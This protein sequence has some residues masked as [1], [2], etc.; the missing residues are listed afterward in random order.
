MERDSFTSDPT[1]L[2]NVGRRS[3]KRLAHVVKRRR[4]SA[5]GDASEA[6]VRASIE[7]IAAASKRRSNSRFQKTSKKYKFPTATREQEQPT[8]LLTVQAT[9]ASEREVVR[10][11]VTPRR[12]S[13]VCTARPATAKANSKSQVSWPF[14]RSHGRLD[15]QG[16]PLQNTWPSRTRAASCGK[17]ESR[18]RTGSVAAKA[19]RGRET[20]QDG[21]MAASSGQHTFLTTSGGGNEESSQPRLKKRRRRKSQSD[22]DD[23]RRRAKAPKQTHVVAA[24]LATPRRPR[25]KEK[26]RRCTPKKLNVKNDEFLS[27]KKKLEWELTLNL[28]CRQKKEFMEINKDVYDGIQ[29]HAS[30][31]NE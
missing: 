5:A 21:P 14:K 1:G 28:Y 8:T 27:L 13:S 11:G 9:P 12:R 22:V 2:L 25:M 30:N 7:N 3:I 23:Y 6:A 17:R 15:L 19:T 29:G 31:G 18:K 16:L 10:R 4:E 26:D 24:G 20:R